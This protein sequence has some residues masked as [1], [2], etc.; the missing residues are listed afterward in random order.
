M[1]STLLGREFCSPLP[2]DPIPEHAL[3]ALELSRLVLRV[4]PIGN[5][6]LSRRLRGEVA[7]AYAGESLKEP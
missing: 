4:D 6:L 5:L 2:G 1:V 3:L 7:L